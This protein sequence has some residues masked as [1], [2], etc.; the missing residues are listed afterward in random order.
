MD[1]NN[2]TLPCGC[3]MDSWNHIPECADHWCNTLETIDTLD[4]LYMD[5]DALTKCSCIQCSCGKRTCWICG[6]GIV[7]PDYKLCKIHDICTM[8]LEDCLETSIYMYNGK[9]LYLG[10]LDT[11]ERTDYVGGDCICEKCRN[12]IDFEDIT[13]GLK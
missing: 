8:L 9:K 5:K 13:L 12:H 1:T 6:S 10:P 3:L 2:Q 7:P 11:Y 4:P